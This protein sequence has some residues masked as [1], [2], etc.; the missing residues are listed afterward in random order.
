VFAGLAAGC[1]SSKGP[2]SSGG[3]GAATGTGG[4]AV[5]V[6]NFAF[7]PGTLTVKA[8]TKVTWT[9]DDPVG[10]NV[11]ANDGSFS[12]STLEN[13]ATYSFTFTKPGSYSY[14]CS[15]HPYMKGKVDV[16]S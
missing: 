10:H 3:S 11:K 5:A 1:S 14:I 15:I 2:T 13:G 7:N 6:K 9:F 4:N 16:T 8:G 12:S